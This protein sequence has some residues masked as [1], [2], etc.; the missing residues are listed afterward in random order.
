MDLLS[1]P[2]LLIQSKHGN[3]QNNLF[4]TEKEFNLFVFCLFFWFVFF[5]VWMFC[6]VFSSI[7]WGKQKEQQKNKP[8]KMESK[9]ELEFLWCCS[10]QVCILPAFRFN[11]KDIILLNSKLHKVLS[12]FNIGDVALENIK[13][14]SQKLFR[15]KASLS[16]QYLGQC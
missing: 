3:L 9:D 4:I 7:Y 5:W 16:S 1:R 15:R 13:R 2:R 14:S 8:N 10:Q 12:I 6:Q 11:V